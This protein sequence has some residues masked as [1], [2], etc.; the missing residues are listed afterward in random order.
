V[1]VPEAVAE[2]FAL[3]C[4]QRPE[5][6]MGVIPNSAIH[7]T[8]APQPAIV[9]QHRHPVAGYL[10]VHLNETG[11]RRDSG[12]DA[13]QRVLGVVAGITPVSDKLGDQHNSYFSIPGLKGI[14][15][16]KL[17]KHA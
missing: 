5:F 17:Q 7:A 9:K 2:F 4:P 6:V 11:T 14:V 10:D 15:A 1:H 12:F 16:D 3:T 13:D 8:D